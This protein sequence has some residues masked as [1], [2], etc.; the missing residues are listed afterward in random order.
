MQLLENK[1]SPPE[2]QYQ[3]SVQC[4]WEQIHWHNMIQW[5]LPLI[6][7][8]NE[9]G[10]SVGAV[11]LTGHVHQVL[12]AC[13]LTESSHSPMICKEQIRHHILLNK[14]CTPWFQTPLSEK[15]GNVLPLATTGDSTKFLISPF[16]VKSNILRRNC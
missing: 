7:E 1:T 13:S 3:F 11:C 4:V 14:K 15:R 5:E 16:S 10:H 6:T 8:L 2:C 9:V 12:D